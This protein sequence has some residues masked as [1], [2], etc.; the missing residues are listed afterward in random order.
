MIEDFKKI[1]YKDAEK[2]SE[3]GEIETSTAQRK[4]LEQR[5]VS[6]VDETG[7]T[8]SVWDKVVIIELSIE[9]KSKK[10]KWEV[11]WILQEL[12]DSIRRP[13]FESQALKEK[14]YRLKSQETYAK[15]W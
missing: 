12:C 13:T 10:K 14:G 7:E 3:F 5:L 2:E 4:N 1:W 15:W 8:L 9:E 11:Q 6:R